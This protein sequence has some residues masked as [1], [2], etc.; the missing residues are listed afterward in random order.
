MIS[1]FRKYFMTDRSIITFLNFRDV[2]DEIGLFWV[3]RT[4]IRLDNIMEPH[5]WNR[6]TLLRP[7]RI[8]CLRSSID[9]SPVD[10]PHILS[11]E[12]W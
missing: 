6:I 7:P 11:L 10:R 3:E 9:E 5:F 12:N 4:A 2:S 1:L 8:V